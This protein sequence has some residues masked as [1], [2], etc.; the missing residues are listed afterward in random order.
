MHTWLYL[1]HETEIPNP[2]D[3]KVR[4]SAGRPLIFCRDATGRGA[5][6]AEL[7]P[8]PRAPCC[9]GTARAT[10]S[11]SS[12]STTRG[13]SATRRGGGD[14]GRGRVRRVAG[15]PRGDEAARR[16][17]GSSIHEGF[18]FVSFDAGRARRCSSTSA[19]PPTSS[20]WR[21]L[22]IAARHDRPARRAAVLGAR[23][24]GS[25]A[26]RTPW[27]ATTSPRRTTPSSATCARP[28]SPS[29]TTTS[30]RTTSATATACSCSPGTAGGSA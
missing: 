23:A 24:T 10:P 8:A 17:R 29:P 20:R 2:N 7:L 11:T 16:C 15:L 25:S 1:G 3:F 9:A 12:A 5:G 19:G 13:R 22:Q 18:V 27:T 14:P 26:S 4:T 28:A 6:L 30:T 21:P